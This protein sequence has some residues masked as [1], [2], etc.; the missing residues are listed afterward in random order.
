[1][2]DTPL[3]SV[4]FLCIKGHVMIEQCVVDDKC[5]YAC[6]FTNVQLCRS[7]SFRGFSFSLWS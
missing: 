2:Q 1:M 6:A 4:L 3:A 7:E 5:R